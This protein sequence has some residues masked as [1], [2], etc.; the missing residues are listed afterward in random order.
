MRTLGKKMRTLGKKNAELKKLNQEIAEE[1]DRR[2]RELI[3]ENQALEKKVKELGT[4]LE[5]KIKELD[6][7]NQDIESLKQQ[8]SILKQSQEDKNARIGDLKSQLKDKESEIQSTDKI[9]EE[10]REKLKQIEVKFGALQEENT[11]L[12]SNMEKIVKDLEDNYKKQLA[13]K[14]K[15]LANAGNLLSEW[16]LQIK[17]LAEELNQIR[18]EKENLEEVIRQPSGKSLAA[19]IEEVNEK[20]EKEELKEKF[21]MEIERLKQQLEEKKSMLTDTQE[22]LKSTKE[23][24]EQL[25]DILRQEEGQRETAAVSTQ[26]EVRH[27]SKGIQASIQQHHV[28]TEPTVPETQDQGTQEAQ[29]Q[30]IMDWPVPK[31]LDFLQP[32]EVSIDI[33]KKESSTATSSAQTILTS[34]GGRD[35]FDK[36][37]NIIGAELKPLPPETKLSDTELIPK[38]PEKSRHKA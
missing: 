4:K 28:E 14:E 32:E 34:D 8:I 24:L 37:Q 35:F 3:E 12:G 10:L 30:N 18:K 2:K 19:E 21:Q 38:G 31:G 11:K 17:E 9:N 29:P 13:E 25:Q 27:E 36:K 6:G 5:R 26:T 7:K 16:Q 22:E 20:K 33:Q 23:M 15:K 1:S